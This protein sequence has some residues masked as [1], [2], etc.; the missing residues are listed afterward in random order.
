MQGWLLLLGLL[1][2]TP[3]AALPC[4][5]LDRCMQ[6]VHVAAATLAPG[7]EYPSCA[8]LR[9][10]LEVYGDAAKHRLL[11]VANAAKPAERDIAG[12]VLADWPAWSQAD[13]PALKQAISRESGGGS[14]VRAIA[15]FPAE[16]ALAVVMPMVERDGG[17]NQAGLVLEQMMPEAL[18]QVLHRMAQASKD[19]R[20]NLDLAL[21]FNAPLRDDEV[22][23][24]RRLAALI[25][26]VAQRSTPADEREQA[27]LMLAGFGVGA[28][29][30]GASILPY[31]QDRD[32]RVREAAHRALRSM[33]DP[34]MLAEI[35]ASC[36]PPGS[37]DTFDRGAGLPPLPPDAPGE[38]DAANCF[39]ALGGMGHDAAAVA[40]RLVPYLK[41]T[42]WQWRVQAA[43]TL[44][45]LGDRSV[46]A[47]LHPL[48]L[49]RD[50]QVVAAAM[51]A[52]VRLGDETAI[53]ALQQVAQAHW[54]AVIRDAAEQTIAAI[55][56]GNPK[57]LDALYKTDN[58]LANLLWNDPLA[59]S[60]ADCPLPSA[61]R[62]PLSMKLRGGTLTGSDLGES[63]GELVWKR[64]GVAAHALLER[65]VSGMLKL[66]E[67]SVWVVT[68]LA[69]M[70]MGYAAVYRVQTTDDG[71]VTIS[72]LLNLPAATRDLSVDGAGLRSNS[73][74]GSYRLVPSGADGRAVAISQVDCA[75]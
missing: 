8:A 70:G 60:V 1:Q 62:A 45:L 63:G 17:L 25:E 55:R 43:Q 10:Q 19:G 48:L 47:A 65:N 54:F 34:S 61:K 66:S 46:G 26:V 69:H 36:P 29:G 67:H 33:L 11:A 21:S 64:T 24:E 7:H 23:L 50:W 37:E 51:L 57:A 30:H 39:D 44:G 9:E 59:T 68:G 5:T 12:C 40:P 72:R 71:K 41:S 27:L 6:V 35:V 42:S 15:K 2:A 22:A 32:P 20:D 38:S 3:A 75:H 56:G 53:P 4:A 16:Q 52:E 14:I 73:W 58:P 49:D 18:P 31:L 13:L 74:V 28:R